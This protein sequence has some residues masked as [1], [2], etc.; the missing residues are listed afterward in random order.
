MEI[1]IIIA[2]IVGLIAGL[3]AISDKSQEFIFNNN[4]IKRI[5]E[6]EFNDWKGSG[7]VYVSPRDTFLKIL[8]F[9]KDNE[10]DNERESFS[11][12]LCM[13]YGDHLLH[14]LIDRNLKNEKA[15]TIL[16]NM[17]EKKGVRVGWRAEY[18]LSTMDEIQLDLHI[19]LLP[20]E[21]LNKEKIQESIN[22]VR[23]RQV[24]QYL[25]SIEQGNDLKLK[26]Y[27][28]EVLRQITE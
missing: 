20:S 19:A 16:L 4:R 14:D 28:R 26:N 12:V 11:L 23:D 24:I 3:I 6:N 15:Y 21:Y 9:I 2:T 1:I 10:F 25:K 17:L 18:A 8:N 7:R 5:F 22:R 13:H 27:A